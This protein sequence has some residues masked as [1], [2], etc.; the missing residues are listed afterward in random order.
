MRIDRYFGC[1]MED[2]EGFGELVDFIHC[3]RL[4]QTPQFSLFLSASFPCKS[5]YRVLRMCEI[6]EPFVE[7][8]LLLTGVS[9]AGL[10]G[11][12]MVQLNCLSESFV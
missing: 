3:S 4:S 2:T 5:C 6:F 9:M 10:C 1:S 12:L 11:A 8:V 7:W